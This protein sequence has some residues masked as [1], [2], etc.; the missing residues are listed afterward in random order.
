MNWSK[1]MLY[2]KEQASILRLSCTLDP[3]QMGMRSV[4]YYYGLIQLA[5]LS[6]EKLTTEQEEMADEIRALKAVFQAQG[7]QNLSTY[8]SNFYNRV[9]TTFSKTTYEL[10]DDILKDATEMAQRTTGILDAYHLYGGFQKRIPSYTKQSFAD[11]KKPELSHIRWAYDL[12]IYKNNTRI[13]HFRFKCN[14]Q[15]ISIGRDETNHIVINEPSVSRTHVLIKPLD[16]FLFVV[17][18]N[19]TSG[20]IVNNEKLK[21]NTYILFTESFHFK[22]GTNIEIY[23][24]RIPLRSFTPKKCFICGTEF[25]PDTKSQILCPPC[26]KQS[27]AKIG[28]I[29]T[30]EFTYYTNEYFLSFFGFC[31]STYSP[32]CITDISL[33][34]DGKQI[35]KWQETP[36]PKPEKPKVTEDDLEKK[37]AAAELAVILNKELEKKKEK[38]P[39]EKVIQKVEK[40][41]EKKIVQKVEKQPEKK[42]VEKVEKQPETPSNPDSLLAHCRIIKEIGKGGM[43]VVSLIEHTE[44]HK[45]YAFKQIK[46][47]QYPPGATKEQIEAH[48][49]AMIASFIREANLHMCFNHPYVAQIHEIGV[50]QNAPYIIME[51]YKDGTL[52]DYYNRIKHHPKKYELVRQVFLQI[53]EGLDY[54]HHAKV[55]ATLKDGSIISTVGIVHR[56]LKP[57]NIFIAYDTVGNPIVKI[58]DFGMAKAYQVASETNFTSV[59]ACGGT[60]PFMPRQQLT[61]YK[62]AKPDVDLWA[63]TASIYMLLTSNPPKPFR[64]GVPPTRVVAYESAIP[65]RIYDKNVPKKF[66]KIIDRALVDKTLHYKEAKELIKD[67]NKVKC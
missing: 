66:A 28:H 57:E 7:F 62:Y 53:L 20:V 42:V 45:L 16:A 51:Y 21:P 11:D 35:L 40:Q 34:D 15:H 29:P 50:Y 12:H 52:N 46:V 55:S 23:V 30:Y 9:L 25:L 6:E 10:A 47:D 22:I 17:D 49:N 26:R 39:E 41:P 27:D 3:S 2:V 63:A 18:L 33:S 64:Q 54:L 14:M 56:D 32:E 8:A 60:F 31:T 24:E 67:L 59:G 5:A 44:T 48:Q 19:S 58:A 4:Y 38:E 37:K 65:I 61:D 43:G 13:G 1:A 36:K